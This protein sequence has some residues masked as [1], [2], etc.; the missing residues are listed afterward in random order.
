VSEHPQGGSAE[1]RFLLMKRGLYYRPDN[2]GYTGIKERAGRY[3]ESDASPRNGVVAVHED[4][5][6]DFSPACFDDLAREHL[7]ATITRLEADIV[8]LR[9]ALA[10]IDQQVSHGNLGD[11]SMALAHIRRRAR[12]ALSS[13]GGR[14]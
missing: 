1:P 14:S 7:Q 12:E 13:G 9:E 8:G 11:W 3:H 4:D 10:Y 5:A 6:E 2:C